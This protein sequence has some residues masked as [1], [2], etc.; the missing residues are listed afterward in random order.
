M[1]NV[2]P[3]L[4]VIM[5]TELWPN[6]FR[7]CA[8]RGLPVLLASARLSANSV[9]RYRRFDALFRGIFTDNVIVAAQTPEDAERFRRIGADS[10]KT[11]VVGNVKFDLQIEGDSGAQASAL[12]A[13]SFS[14][15]PVWIA[16]ST[17]AGEEEQVLDAHAA[18]CAH[19]PGALLILVPRH[20]NRFDGVAA[21][22]TRRGCAFVRRSTGKPV[23]A[24]AKVLLLDSV[25]ELGAFYA[26][27]DLAF[28]GGSLVPIGG[29]NL[30]EPAALGI[31][32]LTGPSNFNG[33]E[34]A[35]L[36]LREGAV[37]R[38]ADARELGAAVIRLF[39]QPE[40]RRRIGAR[41]LRTV[42]AHRG[43]VD[44][45]LELVGPLVDRPLR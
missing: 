4:A 40:S 5:E 20:P 36:L 26:C 21:L 11:H 28:V 44:R 3:K 14:G 17:H 43:S 33:K 23:P 9:A 41:G 19:L 15:R 42:A 45:L 12:R 2:E 31:P 18:L 25:G 39:D 13:Q 32:V 37:Q 24:D 1:R 34:I 29:H 16:G 35:D 8:R 30:L 6:L 27:A 22:L 10:A 7:E 38:I